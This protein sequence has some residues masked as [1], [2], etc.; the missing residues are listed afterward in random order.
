MNLMDIFKDKL[1]NLVVP[2]AFADPGPGEVEETGHYDELAEDQEPFS[3]DLG[4]EET[5]DA[6]EEPV[7]DSDEVKLATKTVSINLMLLRV[8]QYICQRRT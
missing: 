6:R 1:E 4:V 3:D 7:V 8:S 2:E 5:R